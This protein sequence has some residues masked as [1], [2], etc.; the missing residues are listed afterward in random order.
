MHKHPLTSNNKLYYGTVLIFSRFSHF[1][2]L[3]SWF[4]GSL[5]IKHNDTNLTKQILIISDVH[6]RL[7]VWL[8]DWS[9]TGYTSSPGTP[10]T[11]IQWFC[12][13]SARW[14]SS[15]VQD[16]ISYSLVPN[17][18]LDINSSSTHRS[19]FVTTWLNMILSLAWK[20]KRT[21]WLCWRFKIYKFF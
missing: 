3:L 10:I 2:S 19:W 5:W 7:D 16:V 21:E 12:S 13:F 18:V 6:G 4:Y 11:I 20:K 8:D 1:Y 9:H 14:E 15:I 17:D